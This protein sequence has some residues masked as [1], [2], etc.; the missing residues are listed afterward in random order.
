[1]TEIFD[2]N[3]NLIEPF[4]SE[5]N[6]LPVFAETEVK[7]KIEEAK[8]E[9][10]TEKEKITTSVNDLK[11]ELAKKDEELKGMSDKDKNFKNLRDSRDDLKKELDETKARL[12]TL[13]VEFQKQ[14]ADV[15]KEVDD[16][17]IGG[18]IES[19]VGDDKELASKVKNQLGMFIPDVETD[20]TKRLENLKERIKNAYVIITGGTSG[21]KG[22]LA[23]IKGGYIPQEP[24][25]QPGP[26]AKLTD[27]DKDLLKNKM[28]VSDEDLRKYERKR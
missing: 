21:L 18:L 2:E 11:A 22:N 13:P 10:E 19:Y 25:G 7:E 26:K 27:D 3:G 14:I 5:G 23:A 20:P 8:K 4:D 12:E 28:G 17:K 9:F 24:A 6:P 16:Q 15:R 1:M